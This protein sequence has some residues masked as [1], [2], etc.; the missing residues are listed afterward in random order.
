MKLCHLVRRFVQSD[1]G[2][3][4]TAVT[5]T[6]KWQQKLGLD[7]SIYTTSMLSK[8][9]KDLL[10]GIPIRRFS[11]Q[12]PWLFLDQK[13]KQELIC[14]GG[15]PISLPLFWSLLTDP[16]IQLIHTHVQHRLG[17]IARTVARLRKIPYITSIHGGYYTIP[18]E[19]AQRMEKPFTDKWEW[20][21]A[22]GWLTGARRTLEDSDAIICVGEDERKAVLEHFPHQRVE[23]IPHGVN[24][25]PFETGNPSQIRNC[26]KISPE[27]KLI[28]CVSR[29]DYQKD[30]LALVK[31]FANLHKQDPK[32]HLLCLGSVTVSDYYDQIL[33][34]AKK[35]NIDHAFTLIPGLPFQDP[36]LYSAYAAADLFVLPS[37]ME[38]FGIVILEAWAAEIP[39]IAAPVGGIPSFTTHGKNIL[40]TPDTSPEALSR[41]MQS[42]LS[43]RNLS[44]SLIQAGKKEVENYTWEK[45][46]KQVVSLYEELIK[47]KKR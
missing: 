47:E 17:G 28:L 31:A 8:P 45:I 26:L 12:F 44:Q 20:G 19:Q 21:K 14:K 33:K 46:T 37:K 29:I 2:G 36:L 42:V 9:G 16:S 43:N 3:I 24:A 11:Y 30:Q 10:H 41:A 4:E 5:E 34:E 13:V 23:L 7:P 27:D 6:A 32:T 22:V 38:P 25:A 1:W 40:H 35:L 39:V 15:S 18:K